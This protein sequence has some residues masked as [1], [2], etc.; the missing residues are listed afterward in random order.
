S[1]KGAGTVSRYVQEGVR[2]V[3]VTATGGE[4]G[5]ILNPELDTPEIAA[6]LA[7][8]RAKELAE[9]A[10]I[11]GYDEVMMLGYRDSGM[12]DTEANRHPDS[13]CHQPFD[14]VLERLVAVVR[15]QRPDVVL[16]YDDHEFYPHPDHL[17]VHDLSMALYDAARDATRFPAAGPPW[18]V[19]KIYAPVFT[20]GR[21]KIIHEAIL[22]LGGDSPF[23][24]WIERLDGMEEPIRQLTRMDVTGFVEQGRD[25]LRAHRTQV[26]PDGFWF[27]APTDVV[28]S[29]YPWEDFELLH[30]AVGWHEGETD[31]FA[32]I[33]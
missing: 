20:L 32:G 7:A 28:E 29:V 8:V 2:A 14:G 27:A 13:F 30:S 31:L 25:A 15:A 9:A 33:E 4:A 21:V 10:A 6:D 1:S 22:A 12:P 19:K 24:M 11:I 3:L 17:R 26:D 5:D 16:G 23:G 18:E